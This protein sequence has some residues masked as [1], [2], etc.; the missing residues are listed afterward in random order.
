MRWITMFVIASILPNEGFRLIREERGV[1]VYQRDRG[2]DIELGAEGTIDAPPEVV[3]AVLTDYA[4]HPK[5]LASLAESRVLHKGDKSLEVYQR[6]NLPVIADRDFTLRVTWGDDADRTWV[7]FA[8]V[9]DGGPSPTRG[10]VRVAVNEGSW[11]LLSTSAG[12][13]TYAVYE[14]R[15]QIGGSVP[16]WMGKGRAGKDVAALFEAVR[17]QTKYYRR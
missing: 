12:K 5:W 17:N 2:D 8:T 9:K 3:R 11:R 13:S 7:K 4:N 6:L 16:G 1:K 15:M 14:F 10:V